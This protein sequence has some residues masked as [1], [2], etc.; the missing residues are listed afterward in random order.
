MRNSNVVKECLAKRGIPLNT[1]YPLCHD[2]TESISH[3]LRD[4]HLVKPLWHQL[5]IH[6]SNS[7]FFSQDIRTW[8][9]SNASSR[10]THNV[11]GVPWHFLFPFAIW[12]IWKQRNQVVFSNKRV[13]PNLVKV[14]TMQAMEYVLC[15][16]QPRCNNRMAIRQVRWEKPRSGWVK[17]NT[18]DLLM[19]H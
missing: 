11:K 6:N 14:I 15:A 5:G 19:L 17:L 10:S 13:N 2:Q 1:S 18:D 3:A 16:S 4:C 8:L 7:I 9:T 12:L